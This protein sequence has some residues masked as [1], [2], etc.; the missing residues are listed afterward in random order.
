MS[1]VNHPI[2]RRVSG[3]LDRLCVAGY[4]WSRVTGAASGSKPR[5]GACVGELVWCVRRRRKLNQMPVMPV[6]VIGGG[7]DV[8]D[9]ADQ[10]ATPRMRVYKALKAPI[11]PISQQVLQKSHLRI[12][13]IN[14]SI[15]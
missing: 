6:Q 11:R 2:T 4:K 15:P 10:G 12:I 9:A 3:Q 7:L 13:F 1:G 14:S 8:L 5:H